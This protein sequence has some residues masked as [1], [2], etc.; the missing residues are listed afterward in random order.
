MSLTQPNTLVRAC[1]VTLMAHMA[2]CMTAGAQTPL[3]DVKDTPHLMDREK[4]INLA[5]SA[6]PPA[7]AKAAGVYV[8]TRSGYE[9]ARGSQ[10]G[11]TAIVQHSAPTATE[12]QCMDAEGSRTILQRYLKVAVWRAQGKTPDEIR[13]L[14]KEAFVKGELQAPA[15][16]GVDYM[17]SN[18]NTVPNE[19]GEHVP[20]LPH[21]MFFGTHLTNPDLRVRKE[22]RP[23]GQ[24][25]GPASVA[26]EGSPSALVISPLAAPA[27]HAPSAATDQ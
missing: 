22:L 9:K 27:G 15:R 23:D 1:L 2:V 13:Q 17:L 21:V 10:N 4:E 12:P 19:K 7:V 16:P 20:Y 26:G 24:P 25:I 11:F 18:A 3:S 14:T 6:C 5:L 8:L